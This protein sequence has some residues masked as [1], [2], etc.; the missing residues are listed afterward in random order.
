VYFFPR[1]KLSN[2]LYHCLGDCFSQY[3]YFFSLQSRFF[4]YSFNSHQLCHKDLLI[5]ITME[6]R[7]SRRADPTQVILRHQFQ[8]Y[9]NGI[10]FYNRLENLVVIN[11]LSL[12]VTFSYQLG[13]VAI[14]SS[15]LRSLLL[16]IR[17]LATNSLLPLGQF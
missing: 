5:K 12:C 7:S 16:N 15:L 1:I 14:N 11:T 10:V 17:S 8:Q 3:N 9:M 4:S 2:R 13:L 6:K